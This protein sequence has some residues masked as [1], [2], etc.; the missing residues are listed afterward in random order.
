MSTDLR[1][2]KSGATIAEAAQEMRDNS[3]GFL[4]V[5]DTTGGLVGVVTDRDLVTRVLAEGRPPSATRV[6][7]AMSE[8]V[9][10]CF[11]DDDLGEA[12]AL[13][14]ERGKCRLVVLDAGRSA[15]IGVLSLSD[16]L[17]KER[18]RRAARTAR[19][20]LSR[21]AAGPHRPN[22]IDQI[23]LTPSTTEDEERAAQQPPSVAIGGNWSGTLKEFP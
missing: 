19:A 1:W 17:M 4:M 20:V 5:C 9:V 2:I 3:I 21:E 18:P 22:P 16:I 11:E 8:P 6:F 10:T 12:E 13:M 15:P 23:T 14:Q 7:E